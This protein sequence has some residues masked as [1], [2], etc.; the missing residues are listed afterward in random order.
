[1]SNKQQN[2][3]FIAGGFELMPVMMLCAWYVLLLCSSVGPNGFVHSR[4]LRDVV[5][6]GLLGKK[7][8]AF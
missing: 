7:C 3:H 2:F 5:G 6:V 8:K 1:M 4:K